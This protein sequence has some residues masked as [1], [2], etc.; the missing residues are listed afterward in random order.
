MKER[1]CQFGPGRNLTGILT[2]PAEM[3]LRSDSPVMVMLNA[4]L[5]H[6]VGPH[7]MSVELAQRLAVRGIRSLR[8][9]LGGLGDSDSS[10][11]AVSDDDQ[12]LLDTQDAMDFL[13][14]KHGAGSFVLFG[15]CS[16]A[17]NSYA[18]AI[19]DP[20]V[21]GAIMLDGHGFWTLRSYI[22][23]YLPRMWRLRTWLNYARRRLFQ[24]KHAFE[25]GALLRQ[26]QLRR[27]F[28]T[29]PEVERALQSLVDRGTQMLYFY[30]GGV[31]QYYNYAGQFF[32]MFKNL[33]AY[34]R[35]E[36]EYYPHANHTYTLGE[37]RER[38][39]ARVVQWYLSRTWN[40]R[41]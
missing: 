19:R 35:I 7:R 15:L 1:V 5:L 11:A 25:E 8:F 2:E 38:M 28:G 24:S 10:S 32:D 14:R 6:R 31:E 26:Q 3:D 22:E 27:P 4:G 12:A 20:R 33:D 13:E 40:A 9:D 41:V 18:I 23:H 39:F 21:V 34:G 29:R 16:G 37:D 17:D 30:T 36:V